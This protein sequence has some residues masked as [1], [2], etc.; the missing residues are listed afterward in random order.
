[1]HILT[2]LFPEFCLS[3][4]RHPAYSADHGGTGSGHH[5]TVREEE[6]VWVITI[7]FGNCNLLCYNAGFVLFVGIYSF[8]H[9]Y[10]HAIQKDTISRQLTSLLDDYDITHYQVPHVK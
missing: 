3:S 7:V 5:N 10:I 8:I 9:S 2:F 4:S 6:W 1:M